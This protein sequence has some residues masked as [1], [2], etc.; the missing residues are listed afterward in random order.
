METPE[1]CG[2]MWSS[3]TVL[4]NGEKV[5]GRRHGCR[6]PRG[7]K[8]NICMCTCGKPHRNLDVKVEATV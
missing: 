2:T 1:F 3:Y 7:H 8:G 5:D 6:F 4:K